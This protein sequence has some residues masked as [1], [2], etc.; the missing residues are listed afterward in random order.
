MTVVSSSALKTV[1]IFAHE[2]APWHRPQST[3]GAERVAQFAKHL[4]A[5]GWRAVVICCDATRRRTGTRAQLA[6]VGREAV[7]RVR[8]ADPRESVIVPTPSLPYDGLLDRAWHAAFSSNGRPT[9]SWDDSARRLLTMAKFVTGDYSQS[10]QPCARAAAAALAA[11]RPADLCIAEHSPDAGVFLARWYSRK[12]GT[13]WIAD[14]R[15]PVIRPFTGFARTIYAPVAAHLLREASATIA[16]NPVLAELD[17]ARFGKPACSVP[18]GFDRDDF[19]ATDGEPRNARFTIAYAGNINAQVQGMDLFLSG[20][21]CLRDLIGREAFRDVIFSFRGSAFE[22]VTADAAA[23]G[24]ADAV[25]AAPHVARPEALAG[26]QR[27][28]LLLVLSIARAERQD[29]YFRRGH[30]PAKVFD[31][32]GARRPIVCVPGDGALLDDLIARTATGVVCRTPESLARHLA[33]QL[34][35]W[36]GGRPLPYRPNVDVI[37]RYTRRALTGRLASL[38]DRVHSGQPAADEDAADLPVARWSEP[39]DARSGA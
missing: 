7:E 31:A 35:I 4:P 6:T 19:P 25:D 23:L 10:W 3:A 9:R 22:R 34:T 5:F 30:Y 20:L 36:R 17:R 14:F 38:L 29:E 39:A 8:A 13:R 2:C 27:A 21:A 1:L 18:N 16:V 32:F 15:D 24:I 28:D 26:L 12:F 37:N 11:E 33:E